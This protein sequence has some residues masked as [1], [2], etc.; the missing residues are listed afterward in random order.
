M[1]SSF[2][3]KAFPKRSF[4]TRKMGDTRAISDREAH[5]F[6]LA[7][8]ITDETEKAAIYYL[9]YSLKVNGLWDRIVAIWPMV[10]STSLSCSLNLKNTSLHQITW[11]NAPTFAPT[12]VKGNGV[13]QYG[14][15]SL[16]PSTNT[17]YIDFHLSFYSRTNGS[18]GS[19]GSIGGY[20]TGSNNGTAIITSGQGAFSSGISPFF[21]ALGFNTISRTDGLFI[22]TR[23]SN[24]QTTFYRGSLKQTAT[25][26][27]NQPFTLNIFILALNFNGTPAIY[28][29][30]ECAFASIGAYMSTTESALFDS[31]V[32]EFQT[33]LGR[34]V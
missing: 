22:G 7:T 33:I 24:I 27:Y 34:Q 13:N 5:L 25:T 21:T 6:V 31:I 20:A 11:V 32:Q 30:Q 8:G 9:V 15:I 19:K 10:G 17:S 14:N 4:A 1:F 26:I 16:I 28:T 29:D 3:K 18:T 2:P 23:F 12:G